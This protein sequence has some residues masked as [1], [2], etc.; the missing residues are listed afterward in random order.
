M[1]LL[2]AWLPVPLKFTGD[3]D[4]FLAEVYAVFERD[5]KRSRPTFEDRQVIHSTTLEYGKEA[6]FWHL[7]STYDRGEKERIPD[8]RRCERISW[9]RPI[10]ENHTETVISVWKNVRKS[11]NS[12]AYKA[13]TRVLLW[14]EDLDYLLVLEEW[15]QV[16][17]LV[18][19]YLTDYP[20]TCRKLRKEREQF[21][22]MQKPPSQAT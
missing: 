11:R 18:T 2:P 4:K 3:W 10:I 14:F 20:H 21:L 7:T 1:T 12:K 22:K 19:A 6:T 16:M 15:K 8:L 17:I 13:H 5:F 9:P